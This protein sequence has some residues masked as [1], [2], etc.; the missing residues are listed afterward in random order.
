MVLALLA[1]PEV[2]D[3]QPPP[4]IFRVG[5]LAGGSA[6][7]YAARIEAFRQGLRELGYVEGQTVV[8]EYRYADANTEL[9][10]ALA[11]D[12]VRLRVDVILTSGDLPIRA[13]KQATQTIPI[14]VALSGDLLGPGHVASLAR[15]GGNITGLVTLS[16]ELA[17]KNLELVKTALPK[18]SRVA[19]LWNPNNATNVTGFRETEAAAPAFG[20]QL[21]S[22]AVRRS[23]DLE[24]A[25]Q[26]A[27]RSRAEALIVVGDTILQTH[28]VRIA[29][30]AAR[31]RLPAIYTTQDYRGAGELMFYGPNAAEM[32]RRSATYVDKIFKGAKPG[33]LPIEQ[34]TKFELVINLKT[35]KALGL[36]IPQ[37]LLLRAD[38]IIL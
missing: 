2:S 38:Q 5:I 32:F 22:L 27:L 21:L 35:A 31:S 24:G 9:L 18:I 7:S 28:R 14:V 25:F 13:A 6:T 29:Q 10:P 15:P 34:P 33:D 26:M 30:F 37:S 19:M 11:A 20:I 12:L 17:P 23:E 36:T 4:K 3:A 16:T 1:G 8:I